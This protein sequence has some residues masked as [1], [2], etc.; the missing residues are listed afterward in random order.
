MSGLS[1]TPGQWVDAIY[2]QRVPIAAKANFGAMPKLSVAAVRR[3]GRSQSVLK[4]FGL[5]Q[6]VAI[7]AGRW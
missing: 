4:G 6:A 1:R 7:F 3:A 5:P 2:L